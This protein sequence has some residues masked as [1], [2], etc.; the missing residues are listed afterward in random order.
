MKVDGDVSRW[1]MKVGVGEEML[2][3]RSGKGS[4][5]AR[6]RVRNVLECKC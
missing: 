3:T 2:E 4:G 6:Q 1:V 5:C